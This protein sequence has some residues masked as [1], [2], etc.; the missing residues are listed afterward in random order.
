MI[1]AQE[2]LSVAQEQLEA[3]KILEERAREALGEVRDAVL[4][5]A[6]ILDIG[7]QKTTELLNAVVSAEDKNTLLSIQKEAENFAEQ[8]RVFREIG[9][10]IVRG[11]STAIGS[12]LAVLEAAAAVNGAAGFIPNAAGG[13]S[14]REAAGL[15]RAA[16]REKSAMPAGAGLV[17][18]NDTE[19]IIPMRNKGFIPNFQNGN[20]SQIGAGVSAVKQI[21]ETVVAA[22]A[23]SVTD[24]LSDLT[25]GGGDT[26]DL[27]QD[28][29]IQLSSIG[30]TLESVNESNSAIQ[31]N[32][33]STDGTGTTAVAAAQDVRISLDVNQNNTLSVTGLENLR[34]QLRSA[35]LDT[36]TEQVNEQLEV[37]LSEFDNIIVALQERGILTSFGQ[38]R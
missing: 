11:V 29:I 19:A 32:T 18:A 37:L 23:R 13:L 12:R 16:K 10:N 26:E 38:T 15:I 14:P 33:T 28:I 6:A 9:D 5:E 34:E 21:N 27:L 36:T 30:D 22:I 35:V 31:S 3:A 4:E 17:V 2:A 7:I 1:Q 25:T 20:L 24:A 8:N